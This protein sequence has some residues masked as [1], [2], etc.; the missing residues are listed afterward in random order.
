MSTAYLKEI[1]IL[2]GHKDAVTSL[3][4]PSEGNSDTLFSCSRDKKIYKW[5]LYRSED[6]VGRLIKLYQKHGNYVNDIAVSKSGHYIMSAGSDNTGRIFDVETKECKLLHGHKN[7]VLCISINATDNKIVT[8]S[9]DGTIAL[10]NTDG[11]LISQYGKECENIHQGWI[12][13]IAFIPTERELVVSGSADGTLKVWDINKGEVLNTFIRGKDLKEI[14]MNEEAELEL[15][16]NPPAAIKA[17]SITPDGTLCAYGGRD[18]EVYIINLES[19]ACQRKF[20][21]D[22]AVTALAFGLTEPI[23]ACATVKSIY[24]WDV[25][26]D[27]Q[28]MVLETDTLGTNVFCESLAWSKNN[29][30]AGFSNGKILVYETVRH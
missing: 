18:A 21:V 24:I 4:V 8:G 1:G 10:W 9:M 23:V 11:E 5:Q 29:L 6:S 28:L 22:Y 27:E 15:R 13:C 7:D 3:E 30:I 26:K 20:K 12:T 2:E 17:L 14:K 19:G 25:V 16:E